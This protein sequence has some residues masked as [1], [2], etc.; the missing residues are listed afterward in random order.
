M[1][2]RRVKNNNKQKLFVTC[3]LENYKKNT[4]N[5][6]SI[7]KFNSTAQQRGCEFKLYNKSNID[8]KNSEW[9][10]TEKISFKSVKTSF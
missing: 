2:M 10:S 8:M 5:Y 3:Y 9:T 7:S 4:T 6:Y 1:L